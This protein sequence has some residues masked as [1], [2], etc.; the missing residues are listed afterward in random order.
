M[1]GKWQFSMGTMA[2]RNPPF[3]TTR[4]WFRRTRKVFSRSCEDGFET[5]HAEAGFIEPGATRERNDRTESTCSGRDGWPKAERHHGSS[6]DYGA[7]ECMLFDEDGSLTPH[8]VNWPKPGVGPHWSPPDSPAM[9]VSAAPRQ[10]PALY[11]GHCQYTLYD[12]EW[13]DT[14]DEINP[15]IDALRSC[16]ESLRFSRP[17][18][19]LPGKACPSKSLTAPG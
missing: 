12:S 3:R 1:G 8:P 13:W 10:W 7:S 2:G 18:T 19:C 15:S 4:K 14:R 9:Y 6:T 11:N 17:P 16:A 5:E